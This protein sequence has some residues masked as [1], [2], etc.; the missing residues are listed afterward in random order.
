[1]VQ[2]SEKNDTGFRMKI[3]PKTTLKQIIDKDLKRKIISKQRTIIQRGFYI[4]QINYV[5]TKFPRNNIKIIIAEWYKQ[6]PLKW[7]NEIYKFLGTFPLKK[8][9]TEMQHVRQYHIEQKQSDMKRLIKIYKPYNEKLFKFLG[10]RIKEW[11]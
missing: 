3:N 2:E 7:N 11:M 5:L 1:M 10:Y 9:K 4:D 8:I 6:N